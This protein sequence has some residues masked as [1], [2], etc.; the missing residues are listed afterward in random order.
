MQKY[1]VEF[2]VSFVYGCWNLS[3]TR[4]IELP[5]TPFFDLVVQFPGECEETVE[6]NN[7][8]YCRTTIV[9]D[10]Q[11]QKFVIDVRN[12]WKRTVSDETI[13]STLTQFSGWER[14]DNT[15]IVKLKEL[16]SR[17]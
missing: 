3:F 11:Q 8:E 15:D 17:G 5:F 2:W 16:M 6:L 14:N 7:N 4:E 10:L 13:D 9:Y 12:Y 1:K